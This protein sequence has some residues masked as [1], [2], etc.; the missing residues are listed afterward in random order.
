MAFRRAISH[1][2]RNFFQNSATLRYP[3][4]GFFPPP[5]LSAKSHFLPFAWIR[6]HSR[7][8]NPKKTSR[9]PS[10][11]SPQQRWAGRPPS[12]S[13]PQRLCALPPSLPLMSPFGL[14]CG[15][16]PSQRPLACV[17]AKSLFSHSRGFASFAG[18]FFPSGAALRAVCA[19]S[20]RS[21]FVLIPHTWR[22]GWD[23]NPRDLAVLRFSR[24]AH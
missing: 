13:P 15:R 22:R 17:C 7:A 10:N 6:V 23:S 19:A 14:P 12:L 21:N 9:L 24:P 4:S 11:K 1:R 8:Q 3:L 18:T 2:P 16:L 5:R 20:R